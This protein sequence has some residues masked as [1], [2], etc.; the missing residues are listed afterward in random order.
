MRIETGKCRLLFPAVW[1]REEKE[2]EMTVTAGLRGA[3]F[4]DEGEGQRE[5][6]REGELR[7]TDQGLLYLACS[8]NCFLPFM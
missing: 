1:E 2:K 4:Q 3:S 7:D 8:S 5:G 6:E